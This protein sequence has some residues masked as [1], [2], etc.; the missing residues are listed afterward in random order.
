MSEPYFAIIMPWG[1]VGSNL[2]TST[3]TSE[4]GVVVANEP[5]TV[6][7]SQARE[8]GPD[9]FFKVDIQQ[10]DYLS[11]FPDVAEFPIRGFRQGAKGMKISHQSLIS[12]MMAYSIIKSRNFKVVS[13]IRQNHIKAA[14]SQ[15]RAEQR[16]SKK[17]GTGAWSVPAASKMPKATHI[18]P[19]QAIT[20]AAR[21]AANT[22]QML[23]YIDHFF[24]DRALRVTYEDLNQ[25]PHVEVNKIISFLGYELP[26]NYKLPHRKA[27]SDD[28]S[29]SVLNWPEVREAFSRTKFSYLLD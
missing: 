27:T 13:M 20:R 11:G 1:R 29:Q 28:L 19:Q 3:L 9:G 21:F 7:R 17:I 8:S 14:I 12:P 15:I 26:E 22:A 5:T 23:D 2:V 16:A 10:T 24:S 25:D 4:C 6:I 18:D